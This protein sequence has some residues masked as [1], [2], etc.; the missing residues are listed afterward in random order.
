MCLKSI[1][2][3]ENKPFCAEKV[4]AYMQATLLET[5]NKAH[6]TVRSDMKDASFCMETNCF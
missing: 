6:A 3:R 1:S 2:V 5:A 4:K